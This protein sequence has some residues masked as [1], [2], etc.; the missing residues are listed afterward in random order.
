MALLARDMLTGR[1]ETYNF[2]ST[3]GY[4]Y[5]YGSGTTSITYSIS[6]TSPSSRPA[7]SYKISA[8]IN[9][10]NDT[11]TEISNAF[12]LSATATDGGIGGG[13]TGTTSEELEDM[14]DEE[15]AE[16]VEELTDEKAAALLEEVDTEK[17]ADIIEEVEKDKAAAIMEELTPEKL[18]GTI[19]EM[20][21]KSLTDRLPGLTADKLHSID[22]VV[23]FKSMPDVPTEQLT[24]EVTPE[25]L[26]GLN[27]PDVV[28]ITSDGEEYL[29]IRTEAGWWVIIA[30]TP[31]PIDQL[32]IKTKRALTNVKTTVSVLEERP[33]EVLS[34]MP[35]EKIVR[36]YIKI[37]LENIVPEED[38]DIRHMA[39]YVEREW[40]EQN[41]IHNWSVTLNKYDTELNKWV[42]LPTKRVGEDD[43]NIQYTAVIT[44]FSSTVFAITGTETVPALEFEATNLSISPNNA[45]ADEDITITADISNLVDEGGTYV[46]T[47]WVNGTVEAGKEVTLAAN[48]AKSVS[49]TVSKK[50]EG[51]YEV[52]L[53]RLF[54]SFSITAES[55]PPAPAPAPT[56][57]PAP[58]KPPVVT[59]A[60]APTPAPPPAPAPTPAPP[61]APPVTPTN[62]W[63]IGS[64]IIAVVIIIA[65]V[66][67]IL[68]ARR[69]D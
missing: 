25:A 40:L 23:L 28:S 55:A 9:A 17:A 30:A 50:A 21:A 18:N 41:S 36:T 63:L 11:F 27:L 48:E 19:L 31:A 65:V 49:F 47:L 24:G 29:A 5:A 45:Q 52:R 35:A 58:P 56:P 16:A 12:I 38:I 51:D 8:E 34:D 7:G 3:G 2:G 59:P 62:W 43:S 14:T 53:D 13:T 33:L 61:P 60:P 54:D 1:G 44:D 20:S 39:F 37:S 26:A 69:R 57:A 15:A 64:G 6:W 22:K 32:M 4:T 68:V 66:A 67:W 42:S 10:I 46:V